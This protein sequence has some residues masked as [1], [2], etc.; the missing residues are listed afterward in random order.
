M[1]REFQPAQSLKRFIDVYWLLESYIGEPVSVHLFPD[2]CVD[3]MVNLGDTSFSLYPGKFL[4]PG[5]F[6]LGGVATEYTVFQQTPKCT[7]AGVRFKPGGFPVFCPFPL[8]EVNN[9]IVEFDFKFPTAIT[10]TELFVHELN[11]FFIDKANER[12]MA[13]INIMEDIH[14]R[15]G[16]ITIDDISKK[17]KISNRSLERLFTRDIGVSPK[18][19]AKIVRF[20]TA[21][22]EIKKNDQR[23]LLDVAFDAGYYDHAHL[24]KEVKRYSGQSPSVLI[25]N[26]KENPTLV[27]PRRK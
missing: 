24:T 16:A 19:I 14:F 15:K 1:Y 27:D 22:K 12:M 18:E 20:Q 2:G 10:S 23:S 13:S 26:L 25:D 5:Y 3:L 11:R 4:Q 7:F 9:Q 6:Y 21:L 17:H 8:S